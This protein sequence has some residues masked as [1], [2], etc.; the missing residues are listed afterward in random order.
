[1]KVLQEDLLA[2]LMMRQVFDLCCLYLFKFSDEGVCLEFP[3]LLDVLLCFCT[4]L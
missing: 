3:E 4:P 2:S 1:M